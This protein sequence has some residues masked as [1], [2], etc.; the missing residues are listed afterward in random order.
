MEGNVDKYCYKYNELFN[1]WYSESDQNKKSTKVFE[2]VID[3]IHENQL[4]EDY[5]NTIRQKVNSFCLN[6]STKWKIVNR[7][8][9][10]YKI[11]YANWLELELEIEKY[12][13]PPKPVGRPLLD[14]EDKSERSKRRDASNLSNEM[15]NQTALMVQAAMT[16]ARKEKKK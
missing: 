6:V 9:N 1:I 15:G 14:F 3:K 7:C 2:Y 12:I 10:T 4:A 8:Y 13:S 11:K 5:I 16:S